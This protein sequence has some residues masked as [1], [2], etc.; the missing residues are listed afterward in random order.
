MKISLIGDF[1]KS[2]ILVLAIS[3]SLNAFAN[4]IRCISLA[5][6]KK[7][8]KTK[9]NEIYH[10]LNN[11]FD[12]EENGYSHSPQRPSKS[13]IDRAGNNLKWNPK[14]Q[15]YQGTSILDYK[16]APGADCWIYPVI[17]CNGDL[18]LYFDGED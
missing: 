10:E 6:A 11:R 16:C 12:F 15:V 1:M 3:F 7:I 4:P 8:Y 17:D 14:S 18:D 13:V 5:T 9:T 2:L